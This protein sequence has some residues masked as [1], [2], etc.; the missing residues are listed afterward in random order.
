MAGLQRELRKAR[1][2]PK[3]QAAWIRY[4]GGDTLIPCVIWDLSDEGARLGPAR[5]KTLPDVFNLLILGF[6]S[7]YNAY[8]FGVRTLSR[9]P[10][11]MRC[12]TGWTRIAKATRTRISTPSSDC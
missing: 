11:S 2:R 1:R 5:S 12:A 9:A 4:D 3:R 10:M 7:S 8:G 6:I